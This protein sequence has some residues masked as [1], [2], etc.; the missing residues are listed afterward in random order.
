MLICPASM[1]KTV[2]M[3]TFAGADMSATA[4]G[5]MPVS[6][7]GCSGWLHEG[8]GDIGVVICSAVGHDALVSHTTVRKLAI[9]LAQAGYPTLRFDYP[10]TGDSEDV[11]GADP[12]TGWMR[13]IDEAISFLRGTSV[14]RI[15]LCGVRLGALFALVKAAEHGDVDD[16]V[17]IDPVTSGALFLRELGI[18]ASLNGHQT[19]PN[20]AALELDGVFLATGTA[21]PLHAMNASL[22]QSRPARRCLILNS[23]VS[24][25]AE[26][27]A[28]RL[29]E[30][31]VEV[32]Q[33]EF[34]RWNEYDGDGRIGVP[35]DLDM[36]RTWLPPATNSASRLACRPDMTTGL[37]DRT[38]F[39]RPLLFG[40]RLFGTLCQPRGE[41]VPGRVVVVGNAGIGP[42]HGHARFHVLLARRLAAAGIASLRFD[43][44]GLG[45]SAAADSDA[46]T[47][48]YATD[49]R[50]DIAA[51]LDALQ[52]LGYSGFAA[53]GICS[54]GYHAWQASL[55][56]ERIDTLLMVNP[57]TFSW[58]DGQSFDMLMQTSG[59]S[60][61]FY[62]ATL[63][64]G[65]GWKRLLRREVD[66][67]R[68]F[69]TL[70]TQAVR[71]LSVAVGQGARLVGW[72]TDS[73]AP[74]RAM[75]MLSRRGV[76][77]LVVMAAD[78]AGAD[79]L[80]AYF[81]RNGHRLTAL[82]GNAVRIMPDLDH[83]V[84][85]RAA[86]DKVVD[87]ILEF[88]TGRPARSQPPAKPRG[89]SADIESAMLCET[90]L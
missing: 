49:R 11:V 13:G 59:H 15:I 75:R 79:L 64:Q 45:D 50:P 87:V 3:R 57:A 2:I 32:T 35:V 56:D 61:R 19:N 58:K 6:F 25:H 7:S 74:F 46:G 82:R 47:H 36:I 22:F 39:E 73:N 88:L 78:D 5:E 34:V 62:L 81:G 69:R 71:R 66:V 14:R 86:Q 43:F 44:A 27:L 41:T 48:I 60:T 37:G 23:S 84:T 1:R 89:D 29:T 54:G 51:A 10:G 12:V 21:S 70:R 52:A 24:R 83:S 67:R 17:M 53:A 33:A 9:G 30:L 90:A 68:V 40:N 63:S 8:T 28:A 16:V 85:R 72:P 65:S 26:R 38:F 76:R 80:S 55:Q 42:R 31:G 4:L 20:A 18:A 77:V